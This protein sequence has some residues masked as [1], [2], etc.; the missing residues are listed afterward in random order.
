M[1]NNEERAA[2]A[3]NEVPGDVAPQTFTITAEN[4]TLLFPDN[5]ISRLYKKKLY[6]ILLYVL[7]SYGL[8][9]LIE[10]FLIRSKKTE[11]T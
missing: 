9:S 8:T 6:I 4:S 1:N 10:E 2:A 7:N 3:N 11:E 5:R